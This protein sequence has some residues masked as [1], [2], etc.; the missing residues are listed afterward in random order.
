ME[1]NFLHK[2]KKFIV[3]LTDQPGITKNKAYFLLAE[4]LYVM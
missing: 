1:L 2:S 3:F 4:L